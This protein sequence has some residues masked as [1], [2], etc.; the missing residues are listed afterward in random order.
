MDSKLTPINHSSAG[1]PLTGKSIST[2]KDKESLPI[3]MN[4]NSIRDTL[5]TSDREADGRQEYAKSIESP[6]MEEG[7]SDTER[8]DLLG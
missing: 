7:E 1:T 2:P 3:Q 8:L 4:S 6:E 5:E